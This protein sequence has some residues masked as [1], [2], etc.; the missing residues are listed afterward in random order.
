[1][2]RLLGWTIGNSGFD[3]QQDQTVFSSRPAQETRPTS[4]TVIAKAN[5]LVIKLWGV[6]L[7]TFPHL[8]LRLRMRGDVPQPV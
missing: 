6:I 3:S 8:V 5:I 4:Y 1:M 2:E 7:T